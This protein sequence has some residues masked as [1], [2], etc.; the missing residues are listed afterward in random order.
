MPSAKITNTPTPKLQRMV[1]RDTSVPKMRRI[2]VN[3]K[4]D[5]ENKFK[6][7]SK[8]HSKWRGLRS[9][10][11]SL[12]SLGRLQGLKRKALAS[13]D[14]HGPVAFPQGANLKGPG[15]LCQIQFEL[16]IQT[17]FAT[18]FNV[19]GVDHPPIG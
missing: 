7:T 4:G 3:P 6:T 19:C 15:K 17:V 8:A 9:R 2:Q 12:I 16:I 18:G 11:S 1:L 5:V 14:V 13:F 10:C